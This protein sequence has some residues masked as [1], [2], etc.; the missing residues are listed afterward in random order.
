MDNLPA[1]RVGHR[2]QDL[3]RRLHSLVFSEDSRV[4]NLVEELLPFKQL[5]HNVVEVVEFVE[6][7]Y[8][9]DVGVVQTFE[10]LNLLALRV[11]F[12]GIPLY[13]FKGPEESQLL[14]L[15]FEDVPVDA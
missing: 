7:E 14:V 6:L 3:V 1:V 11:S 9:E 8:L 13:H 15:D 12:G 4:H 10:D 2:L 5:C